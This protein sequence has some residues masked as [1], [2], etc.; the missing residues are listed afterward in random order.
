MDLLTPVIARLGELSESD[1]RKLADAS[2]VPAA[3]IFKIKY[4]QTPNPRVRTVEK[5]YSHLIER[6]AA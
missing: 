5:L 6:A 2:G 4:G 1:M 3:T